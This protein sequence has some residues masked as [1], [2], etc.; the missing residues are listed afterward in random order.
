[1]P[2]VPHLAA[3]LAP[4]LLAPSLLAPSLLA[5]PLA[6]VA[7][8]A[9]PAAPRAAEPAPIEV[10]LKDHRFEP[11][12]ITVPAGQAVRLHVRNLDDSAEEF[13]SPS[14]K[15]EKVIAAHGAAVVHLRPLRPGRYAF[16]GEYHEETARGTVI[17]Q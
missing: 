10:T 6:A 8:L 17:A 13:D 3:R 5:L 14:L 2:L 16:T 4:S 7:L 9:A 1:M 12:E 15:V 11:A